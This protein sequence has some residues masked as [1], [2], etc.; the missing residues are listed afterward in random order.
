MKKA[1]FIV[2]QA[3][4]KDVYA[5]GYLQ[6]EKR[7]LVQAGSRISREDNLPHQ[8]GQEASERLRQELIEIGVIDEESRCFTTDYEFTSTSSAASVI[9]GQSANGLTTW[10]DG[11]GRKLNELLGRRR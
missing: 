8:K 4:N 2:N 10:R 6:S 3:R 11:D 1:L 9:L 7:I 5:T